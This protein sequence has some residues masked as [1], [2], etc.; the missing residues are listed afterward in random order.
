MMEGMIVEEGPLTVTF[1]TLALGLR[2][3]MLLYNALEKRSDEA[4]MAEF[5]KRI[6]VD[7]FRYSLKEIDAKLA[8]RRRN[9]NRDH[10]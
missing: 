4:G 5:L 7:D 3:D 6:A 9:K 10:K 2:R 1:E 8:D